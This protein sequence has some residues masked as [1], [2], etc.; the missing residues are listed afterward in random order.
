MPG[1]STAVQQRRGLNFRHIVHLNL[2]FHHHLL[3][4]FLCQFPFES[5]SIAFA[6]W[7][8]TQIRL[9]TYDLRLENVHHL[10]ITVPQVEDSD[11]NFSMCA[12]TRNAHE[13]YLLTQGRQQCING[14]TG[15]VPTLCLTAARK[16]RAL[17]WIIAQRLVGHDFNVVVTCALD[18][19]AAGHRALRSLVSARACRGGHRDYIHAGYR[20]WPVNQSIVSEYRPGLLR[21]CQFTSMNRVRNPS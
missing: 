13:N 19:F 12:R 11:G 10:S 1:S 5:F 17:E 18:R 9:I 8:H 20:C 15:N 2:P 21:T 7:W 4:K 3:A 14:A 6:D 16:R